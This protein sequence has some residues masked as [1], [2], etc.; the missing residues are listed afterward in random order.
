MND[1]TLHLDVD[2]VRAQQVGLTERDVAQNVLVSLSSSFQ[3]SPTFWLN[4]A[5]GVSYNVAVQDAAV[6]DRIVAGA[7][8]H[9]GQRRDGVH[10]RKCWRTLRPSSRRMAPAVVT[11]YNMQPQW[12]FTRSVDGRDLGGVADDTNRFSS[13]SRDILPRGTQIY[14]SRPGEDHAVLFRPDSGRAGHVDCAGLPADR[15]ELPVVA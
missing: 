11:H 4:P 14:V 12:T 10:S 7:D 6:Q 15:G 5:N 2:R 1:P 8:E 9:A 3:T 13:H